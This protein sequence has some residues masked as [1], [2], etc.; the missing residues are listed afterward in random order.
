MLPSDSI[1]HPAH[2]IPH[3]IPIH[4]LIPFF[5]SSHHILHTLLFIVHSLYLTLCQLSS[6]NPLLFSQKTRMP[7]CVTHYPYSILC[8][9]RHIH[10]A[11][12]LSSV[13]ALGS[14]PDSVFTVHYL[15]LT[16]SSQRQLLHLPFF[17]LHALFPY[18]IC[19]SACYFL[20]PLYSNYYVPPSFSIILASYCVLRLCSTDSAAHASCCI[21]PVVLLTPHFA[22][23]P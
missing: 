17:S 3:F 16:F 13:L 11:F 12:P 5:H 15:H 22:S 18:C 23:R 21:R 4:H 6:L 20:H 14:M 10:S 2:F 1:F 8:T 7:C 19:P 9:P